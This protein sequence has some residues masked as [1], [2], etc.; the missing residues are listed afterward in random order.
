MTGWELFAGSA[1]QVIPRPYDLLYN[2]DAVLA[3]DKIS[4]LDHLNSLKLTP[5]QYAFNKGFV[6]LMAH[7]SAAAISYAEVL[8][9]YTLGSAYFPTFMDALARFK[10]REGTIG[11][12][13]HMIEDGGPDVRMMTPVKSVKDQG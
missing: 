13:N 4:A 11:L 7:N 5:L 9:F 8:R 2:K 1:R 6:E 10:L 12:V 3:E